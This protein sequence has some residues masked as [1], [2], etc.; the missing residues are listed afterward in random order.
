MKTAFLLFSAASL[1]L[2]GCST[3]QY[4]VLQPS[5]GTPPVAAR[6]V[7]IHYEPLDYTLTRDHDRLMV[8]V[9][10]PTDDKIVLLGNRSFVVDP[11]GESHPVRDRVLAPHSYARFV[12]PPVPFTYAYPDYYAYGPG[13]GWFYA[14]SWYDPLWGPGWWGPPP[15]TYREVLTNFD[16]RWKNGPARLHLAYDR[17]GNTFEHDFEFVKEKVK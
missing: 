14:G 10:N 12:L 9:N 16:W 17:A 1:F 3:Y 6:P 4:R 13:W 2:S 5:T 15:M 7:P 8:S 11:F